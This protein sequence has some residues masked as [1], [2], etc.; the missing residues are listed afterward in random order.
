MHILLHTEVRNVANH[1]GDENVSGGH[2]CQTT[3]LGLYRSCD[4]SVFVAVVYVLLMSALINTAIAV[5][6]YYYS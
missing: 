3:V 2:L 6:P 5:C 1:L 4:G